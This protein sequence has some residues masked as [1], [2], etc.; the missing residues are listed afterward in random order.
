MTNI[1]KLKNI[2][3]I[4]F[5]IIITISF[6]SQNASEILF[7]ADN[8]SYDEN[9][10][11]I[12]KGK[13][14]IIRENEII[15]SENIIY[16]KK[17]QI[18]LLP[19]EF[20][21]KD[22]KDNYYYGSK[23]FFTKDFQKGDIN[24]VKILLNDGSRIV[25]SKA[26]RDGQIDII[27]KGVYSPC[28]SRIN[29][30]NFKCP[31]WQL[32]SEK[33]LHD[34]ENLFL[35]QKHSKMR[36][37]NIPTYYFPYIVTP[38]PLRKERKSGFL[39]PS[40]SFNFL[41]TKT[42]QRISTP[43]YFNIS[44][45]KELTFT[46][47]FNYGGGVDNSQRLLFD[48]N[49][50]VS[51]GNLNFDL[52]VDTNLE[53][54]NNNKWFN[55]ASLI[56]NYNTNIN[57]HFHLD[58]NS[59]LQTSKFYLQTTNPYDEISYKSSLST[60]IS[61]SGYSLKK[62]DDKLLIKTTTYQVTQQNEDNKK[63]P[64]VLPFVNYYSGQTIYKNYN[65]DNNIVFYNVF[66]DIPTDIH[67]KNQQKVAHQVSFSRNFIKY[68]SNIQILSELHNQIFFTEDKKIDN[69]YHTG[70]YYR[71]FPIVGLSFNTP[72]K[73]KKNVFNLIYKPHALLA[74][75]FGPPNSNKISNEDSSLSSFSINNSNNLNR[76]SGSDKLDNSKRI[77][78][79]FNVKNS[80][81]VADLNQ[82][83][84]FTDN[85]SFHSASG[86]K[87][88]LS[89]LLGSFI[90][91]NQQN[92]NAGYNFRL[93]VHED[94]IKEQNVSFGNDNKLGN[95]SLKYSDQKSKTDEIITTDKETLN[96]SFSSKKFAKFSLINFSGLYD[97]KESINKEYSIGYNYFDECFGINVD[98]KRNS[99]AK[100]DLKPQDILT[101]M[102]SFKNV[103]SYKSTNLAVSENDKQ[104]INWE[105]MDVN[106]E[107]FN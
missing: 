25:G 53:K 85:S 43:Y 61:L 62:Y 67:A 94:Y 37:L 32:E 48:Y 55:E 21:Y 16:N 81:I 40:I 51:G 18:I 58:I 15:M 33:I 7:Y 65:I 68:A 87:K 4:I 100:E 41:D 72:F 104:D 60:N 77:A 106:N 52:S 44:E 88:R 42:S 47:S 99:Y 30:K 90:F 73:F 5:V 91:D 9:D 23:G 95:I 80:N 27:S 24:D 3:I 35:Y 71:I 56:T 84:E 82:T 105:N 59:A 34:S 36:I 64:T 49:Q 6:R 96:Y 97:L 102:F 50:I 93:D 54:Q 86:N 1:F 14:K 78:Y 74:S 13:A 103:G 83:Y 76:Y 22:N 17:K 89:D 38:S 26:K 57:E 28:T 2:I 20:S 12:G 10:N 11:I 19:S 8:I 66:R 79:G 31:I 63:I 98:F 75:S 101:I 29:I 107:L 69:T 92:I 39:N 46:P 70:N 45:D